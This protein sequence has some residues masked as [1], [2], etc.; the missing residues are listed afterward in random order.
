MDKPISALMEKNIILVDMNDTIDQVSALLDAHKLSCVPVVDANGNCF[1]V[2][3]LPDLL[4]FQRLH[5]NAKNVRAWEVCS[6]KV[7]EAEPD[8]SVNE[9]ARL[10]LHN[11]IHHLVI[12]E[13][14]LIIGIV[15]SLDLID[16]CFS[17]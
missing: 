6:H 15:S 9:V 11:K 7:I 13:N 4:H 10:M 12:I 14:K 5:K 17:L 16:S 1:G 2:I 8:V 3:S